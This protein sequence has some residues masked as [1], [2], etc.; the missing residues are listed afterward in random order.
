MLQFDSHE[1]Q[2]IRLRATSSILQKLEKD[3]HIILNS[4]TL[5]PPDGRASWNLYYYCPHHGV[6]LIWDRHQP[7]T[8][9]C[10][11]DNEVF[12]G[13]PYDNSWWRWLNDLNAKACYELGLLWQLTQQPVYLE[14]VKSILLAYAIHYPHYEVHGNIP[15][16]GP[17]K[18]NAQTL[19]E[20]NCMI[21]FARGYDF[22]C[23]DIYDFEQEKIENSLL[24]EGADFLMQHRTPQLHNHEIKINAA[25]GI[26]GLILSEM[27]YINFALISDYGMHYQL[28]HGCIGE[29][30]WFEGSIHYHYY[31]LQSL[32]A[33][34][35]IAYKTPYSAGSNPNLLKMLKF[36]LELIMSTEDF[37]RINDC[38]AGQE[39]VIHSEI[40]EFGFREYPF[41]I[42]HQALQYIYSR[43]ERNNL[44]A[45]LYGVETLRPIK[46]ITC[47]TVHKP[48]SGYTTEYSSNSK[49]FMLV[50][51]APFGGEHDHYDR[52]NLILCRHGFEI[53]PDLGTTGY[54]ANL[55][56]NYYKNSATHNTLVVNEANQPPNIPEV[57][58]YE[59]NDSYT[60]IDVVADWTTKPNEVDSHT[61]IQWDQESYYEIQ[62]RRTFL[63]F[64]GCVIDISTINNPNEQQ[65]ALHYLVR[66]KLQLD[67]SWHPIDSPF[68]GVLKRMTDC[69]QMSNVQTQE[70]TYQISQQPH[71]NQILYTNK[72]CQLVT[73]YAPDNPATNDVAYL[74]I[75]NKDKYFSSLVVHDLSGEININDVK[76][77][78]QESV[79]FS[80]EIS[81][82]KTH[83]QFDYA[84]S[85]LQFHQ[86]IV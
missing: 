85:R 79:E 49:H 32:L 6:R 66:G 52:L 45:L 44:E 2:Q 62:Y 61:I 51:H 84:S 68:T 83:Y 41:E 25:V 3:N 33:Y 29:G 42:L 39:K 64:D 86:I 46:K 17:G 24:R 27:R 11:V 63:W 19:C 13:E 74:I 70:M 59:K 21:N 4:E 20:A 1:I 35:K 23:D 67:T 81:G 43:E 28:N 47:A 18:A 22:I 71:F 30:M 10:P 82:K 12:S 65:L 38:I 54:G 15:Y 5:V 40:F 76:W 80:L 77:N 60:L 8:H 55:H 69:H 7:T 53:L 16:N 50:K 72:N 58:Y 73:G 14:K 57:L 37:P 34:E 9:I 31:A 56:Y 75:R 48:Y 78:Q 36:P 26:I